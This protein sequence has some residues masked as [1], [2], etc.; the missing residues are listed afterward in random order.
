MAIQLSDHFNIKRLIRFTLPTIGMMVF[1]S[2]YGVVDGLCVSNLIG[3]D[4]LA[5]VNIVMPFPLMCS[6]LGLM[7]GTGGA[8]YLSRLLGRG[9]KERAH[10]LLSLIVL[11]S[12]T[13]GL[14]ATVAGIAYMPLLSLMMGAS[15]QLQHLCVAYGRTFMLC[16]I[17]YIL[18][19]IFQSLLITAERPRL[20]LCFTLIA[21]LTNIVLDLLFIGVLGMGVTGAAWATVASCTIGGFGPLIYLLS[22]NKSLLQMRKP[23]WHPRAL[24]HICF[25]GA[26]EMVTELSVPLCSIL[27]NLQLMRIIGEDG[28]AAYGT[29]TYVAY[30]FI[31]ILLG[32]LTGLENIIGYHY[33]AGNPTEV[34]NLRRKSL[35]LMGYFGITAFISAEVLSAWLANLFVGYDTTLTALTT[36]AFRLY[37][38]AFLIMGINAFTSSLFTAVGNGGISGTISLC[39]AL[40]FQTIA[41][42]VMPRLAGA[43]GIWFSMFVGEF[44]C[45]AVSGWFYWR[46]KKRYN[47]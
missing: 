16:I 15:K 6:S 29:I 45:L 9:Q 37:S 44:L 31:S 22:P 8:A 39:R 13:I 18:Q 28:V 21:G 10:R 23:Q 27:Y 25:N 1:T 41:L 47:Y 11:A 26:S 33:G 36:H 34:Q 42:A 46:N 43:D 5:A 38:S 24:A 20:G 17:P 32:Y 40:I 7:F 35:K 2:I 14:I 3:K 19:N 12:V 30:I 4:A